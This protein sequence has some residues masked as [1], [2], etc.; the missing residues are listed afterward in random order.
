MTAYPSKIQIAGLIILISVGMYFAT[1]HLTAKR[2]ANLQAGI[3]KSITEQKIILADLAETTGRY[4]A[5]T[6]TESIVQDCSVDERNVFDNLLGRLDGGLSQTE[7]L[8]LDRLFGRCGFFFAQ[9]K[10]I[11][12]SRLA[13]EVELYETQI[14]QLES[15]TGSSKKDFYALESWKTLSIDEQKQADLFMNLVRSQDRIITTLISGKSSD[16]SDMQTVLNE[17]KEIQEMLTVTNKQTADLRA[18]LLSQ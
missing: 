12:V 17:V 9:R 3:E 14:V 1:Q 2:T 8:K 5:D 11:M 4:G 13:R 6:T 16:S 18:V 10:S 7:L 15:L